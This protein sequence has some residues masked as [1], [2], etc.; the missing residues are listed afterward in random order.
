VERVLARS[1]AL[2]ETQSPETSP[3]FANKYLLIVVQPFLKRATA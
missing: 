3:E 2:V 1:V